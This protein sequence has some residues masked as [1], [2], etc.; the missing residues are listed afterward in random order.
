MLACSLP[1]SEELRTLLPPWCVYSFLLTEETLEQWTS[2][3]A[4]VKKHTVHRKENILQVLDVALK[5]RP[6]ERNDWPNI[7]TTCLSWG[8]VDLYFNDVIPVS[9]TPF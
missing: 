2:Q 6:R 1:A 9:S 5:N 8:F 3:R 4:E 7:R